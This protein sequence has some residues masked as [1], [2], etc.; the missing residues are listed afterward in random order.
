MSN[1]LGARVSAAAV[2]I[3]VLQILIRKPVDL[4]LK[5]RARDAIIFRTNRR[6]SGQK[7]WKVLYSYGIK[8]S[9]CARDDAKR[10]E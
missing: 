1:T 7:S 2:G 6:K 5:K 10:I 8:S 3:I 4:K 9:G